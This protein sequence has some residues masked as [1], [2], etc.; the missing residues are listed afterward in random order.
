MKFLKEILKN[1][2][3]YYLCNRSLKFLF[4]AA[5]TK[6]VEQ[7]KQELQSETSKS[8][9]ALEEERSLNERLTSNL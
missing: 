8:N 2:K 1:C 3:L 6:Q 4:R 5:L 7:L 9:A